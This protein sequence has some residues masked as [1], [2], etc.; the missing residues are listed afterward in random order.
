MSAFAQLTL[1]EKYASGMGSSMQPMVEALNEELV[2]H[3]IMGTGTDV[4]LDTFPRFWDC[5]IIQLLEVGDLAPE[6]ICL[7]QREVLGQKCIGAFLPG[8]IDLLGSVEP[9]FRLPH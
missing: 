6:S 5:F 4:L 9:M 7:A 2:V 8:I 3:P 1:R